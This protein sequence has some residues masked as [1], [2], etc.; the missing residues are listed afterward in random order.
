MSGGTFGTN[1]LDLSSTSNRYTRTYIQGFMDISG[2][3]LIVRNNNLYLTQGDASINGNL[4]LGR[5][6]SVNGNVSANVN[7]I[8]SLIV[9]NNINMNGVVAQFSSDIAVPSTY[10]SYIDLSGYLYK[11]S[12]T[13]YNLNNINIL[14]PFYADADVSFNSRLF[15]TGDAS[16]N[17]RLFV[18][19]DSYINGL[20]LG[21]GSGNISTNTAFG[22][23][24][25]SSN[26]S[27]TVNT[28]IGYQAMRSNT[29]GDQNTAVGTAALDVNTTGTCNTAMGQS[30]LGENITGSYNTAI[31]YLTSYSNTANHNTAVG[32]QALFN[33]SS[34][35]NN[36]V[37]GA[38]TLVSNTAGSNNV[39]VGVEAIRST[40]GGN[41]TAI[42]YQAGY[43]GTANTSGTN[44][45]YVGYQAQANANNYTKSTALG[46]GATI[47]ASNQVVLG[48]STETVVIPNLIQMSYTTPPTFTSSHIGYY[49]QSTI[50]AQGCSVTGLVYT[51]LLTLTGLVGVYI[52]NID[53][54]LYSPGSFG[55]GGAYYT[56][57]M[58]KDGSTTLSNCAIG[59][60]GTSTN[61][62]ANRNASLTA[63]IKSNNNTI[64]FGYA[65]TVTFTMN[66]VYY[67]YMRIA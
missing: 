32:S 51:T 4:I 43:A 57:L 2:G 5:D 13:S 41:N 11:T 30:A 31:G 22:V 64:T 6:L 37:V 27:G 38:L 65:S 48:T 19:S 3:N 17:K 25:L 14:T 36:T 56:G 20:T 18:G 42:G 1:W 15:L 53:T 29:S 35:G 23:T 49:Y 67:R 44:N 26:T 63:F 61:G 39:A 60:G 21:K 34:G 16:F 28:A 8:S 46:S 58:I 40:T 52:I 7:S 50:A 10:V 12:L 24:A 62:Y 33:T 66:T 55:G 45:T 54:D 59:W 9:S 47:T